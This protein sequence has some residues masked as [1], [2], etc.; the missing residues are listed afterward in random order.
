MPALMI[1]SIQK[2]RDALAKSS[3]SDVMPQ[4]GERRALANCPH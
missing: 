1:G 2:P 3:I 4:V